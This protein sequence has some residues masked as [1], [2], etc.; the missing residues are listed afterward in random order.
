MRFVRE[1]NFS[2]VFNLL[3]G[4]GI[5]IFFSVFLKSDII[6]YEDFRQIFFN[7]PSLWDLY[8]SADHGCFISW[9]FIKIVG[10]VFPLITGVH[11]S[12]SW[13]SSIFIGF[14]FAVYFFLISG[15]ASLFSKNKL[16]PPVWY[17]LAFAIMYHLF[18]TQLFG[19]II[20]YCRH[21]RYV[22][23]AIFYFF[24]WQ[25]FIKIFVNQKIEQRRPVL[26][27]IISFCAGLST[28][29][30]NMSIFF[31]AIIILFVQLCIIL[32]KEKG[33]ISNLFRHFRSIDRIFYLAALWFCAGCLVFYL[34]P[35]FWLLANEREATSNIHSW[36]LLSGLFSDFIHSWFKTLFL[37]DY[38]WMLSI[39][40]IILSIL[41]MLMN[42]NYAKNSRVVLSSWVLILG[43]CIFYFTLLIPGKT[44]FD[45]VSF[46]VVSKELRSFVFSVFLS[47][48]FLLLG[49]FIEFI[50]S[51]TKKEKVIN[52]FLAVIS[53]SILIFMC[54]HYKQG[55]INSINDQKRIKQLMYKIEKMY[56]F[57][58]EKNET[59]IFPQSLSRETDIGS[60]ILSQG[61][62]KG[63]I[64]WFLTPYYTS[65]YKKSEYVPI[66]LLP[67]DQAI[68]EFYSKGGT[69]EKGEIE[70]ADFTKL[71]DKDFVLNKKD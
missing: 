16:L 30:V 24:F 25:Y 60:V 15:F 64:S 70:R 52:A 44:F 23:T 35:G 49:Y 31:S 13:L 19:S 17:L 69:F 10:Y 1:N 2:I 66:K 4:L 18:F 65:I 9:I 26:I 37:L 47:S 21:F 38:Q 22:F 5:I 56:V 27:S 54:F 36:N 46:W 63:Q 8:S 40:L 32:I 53:I 42:K 58:A 14:D 3:V 28:E 33:L 62:F 48:D 51:L 12:S 57:Y 20:T 50:I 45:G 59:A 68:K 41:I 67:D 11:P 71:L 39:G 29:C 43:V 55:Y 7:N 61:M 34:N 6:C